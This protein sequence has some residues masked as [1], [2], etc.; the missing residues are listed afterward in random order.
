MTTRIEHVIRIL[1]EA[2]KHQFIMPK[3]TYKLLVDAHGHAIC[4]KDEQ[5]GLL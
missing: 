2:M 1:E 4:V 5:D 3:Q